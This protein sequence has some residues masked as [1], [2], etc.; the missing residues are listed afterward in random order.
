MSTNNSEHE[1]ARLFSSLSMPASLATAAISP[2]FYDADSL[3]EEEI[4]DNLLTQIAL[5]LMSDAGT[6]A[7]K[8]P[9]RGKGVKQADEA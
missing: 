4:S 5:E 1:A 7:T 3:G 6:G 2:A 8:T 9:K